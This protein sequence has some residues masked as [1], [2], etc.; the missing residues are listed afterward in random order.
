MIDVECEGEL[1]LAGLSSSV[2]GARAIAAHH[3]GPD[4]ITVVPM[5]RCTEVVEL[6]G[7]PHICLPSK[8][9]REQQRWEICHEVG[10]WHLDRLDYREQDREEIAEALAAVLVMPRRPL[11]RAIARHGRSLPQLADAFTTTQTSIALRLGEARCV[12]ASAVVRPG[13]VRVRS[14]DGFVMPSE[15]ELVAVASGA[16]SPL[17]RHVLT[18]ARRRVALLVA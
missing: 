5:R 6:Y 10:E 17:E 14:P 3:F 2:P 15:R 9:T 8:L 12:E 1:L 16:P 11:H 13:L 18:D 4:P 7:R